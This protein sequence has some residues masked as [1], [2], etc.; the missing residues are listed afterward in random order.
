MALEYV[1]H[2][3][4]VRSISISPCGQF[5]AT[6]DTEGNVVVWQVETTRILKKYRTEKPVN[7]CLAWSPNKDISLLLVCNEDNLLIFNPNCYPK[8]AKLK[9]KGLLEQMQE[10]WK[11]KADSS[12]KKEAVWTLGSDHVNSYAFKIEFDKIIK[13]VTWHLK[14]DYFS[15]MAHNIQSTS[16][17]LIHQLT[18]LSS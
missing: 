12:K 18:T 9:T 17:V 10:A 6:C 16:Q 5:L 2:Q 8:E 13:S 4:Q 15:T 14:G 11:T 1:F 7:D 3:S